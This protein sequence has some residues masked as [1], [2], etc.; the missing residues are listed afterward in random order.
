MQDYFL[1]NKNM[2]KGF[3]Q[4]YEKAR[5]NQ[6]ISVL[7]TKSGHRT[8]KISGNL[9]HSSYNPEKEAQRFVKNL[10]D[11]K[12]IFCVLGLGFGY[13][14]KALIENT[15]AEIIIIEPD[16]GVY[17]AAFENVDLSF[18]KKVKLYT[19]DMRDLY[20][21]LMKN[22]DEEKAS[23]THI[24]KLNSLVNLLP[25]QYQEAADIINT[26]LS[27]KIQ[28]FLTVLGFGY[29]WVNNALKNILAFKKS[30]TPEKCK[31]YPVFIIASGPGL[32][33]A[34]PYIELMK[35]KGLVICVSH[36]FNALLKSGVKPHVVIAI[37]AGFGITKH[38]T[39][40]D[41]SAFKDVLL[42]TTLSVYPLVVKLWQGEIAVVNIDM[43]FEREC[44]PDA[45]L[46]PVA[47]TVSATAFLLSRYLSKSPVYFSGLDL[48]FTRGRYHHKNSLAEQ[49][50]IY[51]ANKFSTA[52]T[53]LSGQMNSFKTIN[54]QSRSGGKVKTNRAMLAYRDW[55]NSAFRDK[56]VFVFGNEGAYLE[57][58]IQAD[59]DI[60]NEMQDTDAK[61]KLKQ[62]NLNETRL[63]IKIEQI[64]KKL[65][66]NETDF[67]DDILQV[68]FTRFKEFD[69]YFEIARQKALKLY[70]RLLKNLSYTKE[71]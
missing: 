23:K 10:P 4:L 3:F 42:I 36:S 61:I 58:T 65:E 8:L 7:D 2:G 18:L 14:I 6:E 53:K 24:L 20:T 19:G 31:D 54:V 27:N 49:S 45:L 64:I 56:N 13:H 41:K 37:D 39:N 52:Q 70:Q 57:N 66:T 48:A 38:F 17:K 44:L 51:A 40:L 46:L 12:E 43:P 63:R 55:L 47:G 32:D 59:F 60:L 15:K 71:S 26:V 28:S 34:M 16:P 35:R 11:D 50:F 33:E 22:I 67:Q 69:E 9:I 29:R 5:N 62:I 21:F 1:K 30:N 25:Y 68:Q